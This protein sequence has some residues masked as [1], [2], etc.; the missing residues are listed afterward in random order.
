MRQR[1]VVLLESAELDLDEIADWVVEFAS[2]AAAERYIERIQRRIDTLAYGSER[3]TLREEANGLRIIGLFRGVS[4]AFVVD[5]DT[6]VVHRV[7]Y[8]GR[9]FRPTAE[10]EAD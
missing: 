10:G 6:V 1:Q 9:N 7:L 5:G 2:E 3:G 8:R 4:L